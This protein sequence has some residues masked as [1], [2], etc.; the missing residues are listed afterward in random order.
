[1]KSYLSWFTL[2]EI[3][4]CQEKRLNEKKLFLALQRSIFPSIRQKYNWLFI[5]YSRI[6]N[7]DQIPLYLFKPVVFRSNYI[8]YE[9]VGCT[10]LT[11]HKYTLCLESCRTY[12]A[13]LLTYLL[14]FQ[15][16][17]PLDEHLH[18]EVITMKLNIAHWWRQ[19]SIQNIMC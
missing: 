9:S 6:H 10:P 18:K 3:F 2:I 8:C 11:F 16:I 7:N 12:V 1:M 5:N 14:I 17:S 15:L 19:Q 13:A 4:E